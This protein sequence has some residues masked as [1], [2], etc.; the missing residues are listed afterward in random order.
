MF[1]KKLFLDFLQYSQ[2]SSTCVGVSFLRRCFPVD[3]AKFLRT[4]AN[5]CFCTSLVCQKILLTT[6]TLLGY[7][8]LDRSG[9]FITGQ[10]VP[11]R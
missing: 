6:K 7:C 11:L 9:F 5:G 2:K 8:V 10:W 3:I 4:S 1:Y